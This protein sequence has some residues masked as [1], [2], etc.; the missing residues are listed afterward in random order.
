MIT[1]IDFRSH[2]GRALGEVVAI[3]DLDGSIARAVDDMLRE[4]ERMLDFFRSRFPENSTE[5]VAEYANI[6]MRDMNCYE[7]GER[8]GFTING[9]TLVANSE[10]AYPGGMKPYEVL[11]GVPS[12]VIVFANDL[13]PLFVIDDPDE[14]VNSRLGCKLTTE[15]YA[16]AGMVHISVGN[17]CPGV[18]REGDGFV[19]A[20]YYTPEDDDRISDD[21]EFTRREA[22]LRKRSLGS[23]CTD[24]WW[25][26]AMD[27]DL[28]A[29][30]ISDAS[31]P[32]L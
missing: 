12:G 14:S 9:D 20:N 10:C 8:L 1:K 22:E 6:M 5:D 16:A 32:C 15:A 29:G 24:L 28:F 27:R 4:R 13:R 25:F 17:T 31:T 3:T 7:C 18:Y 26:S 23:I 21:E 11:L 30:D 19:V 2:C